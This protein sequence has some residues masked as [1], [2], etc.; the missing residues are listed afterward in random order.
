VTSPPRSTPTLLAAHALGV[1]AGLWLVAGLLPP[2]PARAGL[3]R[4]L[5]EL[6][7][8]QLEDRLTQACVE[9]VAGDQPA[10]TSQL[11]RPCQQLAA[12]TSRCL[13][14]ETDASGKGLAVLGELLQREL[15]PQGERIVKRCIAKQ[16]GLPANSLESLSLRQLAQRFGGSRR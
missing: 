9:A 4:P 15:G 13:V 16:L 14:R 10:L 8:P 2:Q 6:M 1:V 7:R 11:K 5:L 3:W 12:P